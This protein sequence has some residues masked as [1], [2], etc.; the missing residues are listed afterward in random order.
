MLANAASVHT[1]RWANALVERGLRVEL[2]SLER[3]AASL[4]PKV[5]CHELNLHRPWGYYL[6]A[7]KTRRL[8]LNSRPDLLHAHYA[9]GYGTLARL[10]RYRPMIPA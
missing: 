6:A 7:G 3:A 2:I 9:S 10:C 5:V 8:L 4:S 1:V